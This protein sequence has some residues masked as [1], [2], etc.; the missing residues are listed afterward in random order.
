MLLE[1]MS[2]TLLCYLRVLGKI[3]ARH[4]LKNVVKMGIFE[5][6]QKNI[7]KYQKHKVH[8][9][10]NNRQNVLVK[11]KSLTDEYAF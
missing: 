4:F 2:C 1:Q 5:I 10:V 11:E 7:W 9:N 6:A 3:R 8:K